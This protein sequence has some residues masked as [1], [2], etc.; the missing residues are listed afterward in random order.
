MTDIEWWTLIS[1]LV[2]WA[3][4]GIRVIIEK[5]RNKPWRKDNQ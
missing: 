4:I 1:A 5:Q 3:A 2:V